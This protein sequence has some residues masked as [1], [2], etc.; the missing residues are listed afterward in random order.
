MT[1]QQTD[2]PLISVIIP[3]YNIESYVNKCIE[4][5]RNQ[6]Y[7]NL[8][9]ITVNDGSTDGSRQILERQ[10]GEDS[11]IKIVNTSNQGISLARENGLKKASGEYICFVDGDDYIEVDTINQLYQKM[12]SGDYDITC[13][14]FMRVRESY[15]APT[16]ERQ[17]DDLRGLGFLENILAHKIIVSA[18]GKLYRR[19]LLSDIKFYRNI[20][21]GEDSLMNIQIGLKCPTVGYID[22]IGYN[23]Y[24]RR[25]SS[26]H[27]NYDMTYCTLFCDTVALNLK[28]NEQLLGDR[29]EFF[30]LLNQLRW[31]LVYIKKSS[32]KWAGNSDYAR[33]INRQVD[34]YAK[35]LKARL[36]SL[37]FITIRMYRYRC[38]KPVV[39]LIG[40]E[41]RLRTSIRRRMQAVRQKK[42]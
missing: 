41:H 34:K 28:K 8:E 39:M 15:S 1:A 38:L 36:T 6:S 26:N 7:E 4:S 30:M 37:D 29:L 20:V 14:N 23:Y 40:A 19:E 17:K 21:M 9:I 18:C 22:Y 31:Y 11:R 24:Q 32:N 2:L 13:C 27:S 5:I 42:A 25:G 35:E 10:A 33:N 16:L 12:L 3:I